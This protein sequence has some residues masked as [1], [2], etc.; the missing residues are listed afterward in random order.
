MIALGVFSELY[1]GCG[2]VQHYERFTPAGLH[3]GLPRLIDDSACSV[4]REALL[5]WII[6]SWLS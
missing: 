4:H 5:T 2:A 6:S 1:S 3:Q